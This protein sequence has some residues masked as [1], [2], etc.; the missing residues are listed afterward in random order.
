MDERNRQTEMPRAALP[1]DP[2][3][4]ES[5]VWGIA[6]ALAAL[7][8]LGQMLFVLTAAPA[9][10]AFHR[11]AETTSWFVDAASAVGPAGLVVILLAL[12]ALIMALFMRL[13]RRHWIGFAY[14]PPVLYLGIGTVVVGLLLAQA[15]GV[16]LRG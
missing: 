12:D 16:F 6:Y 15:V 7:F 3:R 4:S 8:A 13:A 5:I 14:L 2:A 1:R 10:I 11:E 9:A